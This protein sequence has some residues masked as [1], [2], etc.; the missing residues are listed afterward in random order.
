MVTIF[1]LCFNIC[2]IHGYKIAHISSHCL[3]RYWM[4]NIAS[5]A[6]ACFSSKV[7]YRAVIRYLYLKGKTGKEIYSELA[8]VYGSSAPFYA[9]VKFWVGEFKCG[10]MSFEDE[11]R[12]GH[13]LDATDKEMCKNVWD[14]AY[15]DRRIQVEEIVQALGISHGSVS[16]ILHDRSVMCKLTACW[17]PKSLSDEQMATRA[18]VCSALMKRFR[19]KDDF[20]LHLVTVDETWVHYCEPENNAQSRQRVGPGSPRPKKFK[21]QQ[22]AGKV[23][24][25]VF[26]D[27]KG[28][29]ML[30]FLPKRSTITGV[31]SANLL[32][33][34]RTAIHEKRRGKLSKGVLLQQDNARVHTCKVAMDAVESNGYELIP[35]PA[36]SPDLA[37]SD[38]FLFPLE[39]G[40]PWT[41]FPGL[42][43]KST[44]V[45]EWVNGKDPD[46]FSSGLMALEH[47]WSKC[48]TL[49]GNY[50][51]KEGVDL[52]RK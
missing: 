16:T 15:S 18:S 12:S 52:N 44:A 1:M 34:L 36:Y 35:H 27:T 31:Y 17:V 39:K 49:E 46:F 32:D 38:F 4:S 9:Q 42:M 2:F 23:M 29:I 28:V 41:S 6:K 11:A 47:R 40:Y 7:E 20:L 50:T 24:A 13:P 3:I 43:K 51:E 21:T 30:D 22:S 26:W 33:Q 14:L 45:E 37:P 5:D 8:D 10:R 25:T 48:I 19:S